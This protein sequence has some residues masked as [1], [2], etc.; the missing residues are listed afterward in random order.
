VV[1]GVAGWRKR[2]WCPRRSDCLPV[3]VEHAL[4]QTASRR[5]HPSAAIEQPCCR[6][7][8]L[9]AAFCPARELLASR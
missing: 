6:P 8:T 5:L 7:D 9:N 2:W 3:L 4:L 1:G